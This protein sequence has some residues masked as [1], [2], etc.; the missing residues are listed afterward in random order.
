MSVIIT[1]LLEGCFRFANSNQ[2]VV[3]IIMLQLIVQKVLI[4][5][6]CKTEILEWAI[7][8]ENCLKLFSYITN[9]ICARYVFF[10]I[11]F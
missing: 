5:S 6:A 11:C 2:C 1:K 9:Q 3:F 4:H 8:A 7:L 10:Y